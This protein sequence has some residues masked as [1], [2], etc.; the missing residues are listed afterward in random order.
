MRRATH[1][2]VLT[3]A[4]LII[5]KLVA[6]SITGSVSI[7]A[8]LVDSMLDAV[9]SFI[10]LLAVRYALTPPDSEHRFGH[11]KA[12][13]LVG[14]VQV[15]FICASAI[16]LILHAFERLRH[17]IE[18]QHA[19]IGI[20]VMVVA[21]ALT[22][23]LV[24]Y[25][26]HVISRTRS[27]VIAADSLHYL[28]DV[29]TNLSVLAAL[30]LSF[31]GWDNLDAI[32]AIFIAIFILF[33]AM[34]IGVQSFHHL[35]DHEISEEE[36]ARVLELIHNTP[37][38]L[39]MHDLRTR[40]SG[41]QRFIQMHLDLNQDLSLREAHEVVDSVENRIRQLIEGADVIVHPDPVDPENP[42]TPSPPEA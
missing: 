12:E 4:L 38:V 25:Q 40:Q 10:N 18:V 5:I 15:G 26:R 19:E 17:S 41:Q 31:Y 34:K 6:W 7:L 28:T 36:K 11:G 22:I 35:M 14:F 8:S 24:V 20:A 27:T 16:F 9:V 2:A 29:L 42:R 13:P 33:T 37:E 1:A 3:A 39:G 32:I 23:A 30:I 21:T